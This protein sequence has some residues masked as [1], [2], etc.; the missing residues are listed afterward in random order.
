MNGSGGK[1]LER[2]C[3]GSRAPAPEIRGHLVRYDIVIGA[4]ERNRTAD[5]LITNQLLYRLSYT[6]FKEKSYDYMSFAWSRK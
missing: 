5:L 3:V 2:N 1:E 4:S 6:G